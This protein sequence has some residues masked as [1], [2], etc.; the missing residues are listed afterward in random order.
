MPGAP[1]A[2]SQPH[3]QQEDPALSTESS[4]QEV[5]CVNCRCHTEEPRPGPKLQSSSPPAA[6]APSPLRG[7]RSHHSL[8]MLSAASSTTELPLAGILQGWYRFVQAVSSCAS[9]NQPAHHPWSATVTL[10]RFTCTSFSREKHEH[11]CQAFETLPTVTIQQA[12]LESKLLF[13]K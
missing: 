6:S 5:A 12:W 4:D 8:G 3:R 13:R 1:S 11:P 10:P 2:T 7:R 9:K